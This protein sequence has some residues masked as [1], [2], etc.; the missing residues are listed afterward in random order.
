MYKDIDIPIRTKAGLRIE[1]VGE[2]RALEHDDVD[3]PFVQRGQEPRQFAEQPQR[4]GCLRGRRTAK[5][6]EAGVVTQ[7]QIAAEHRRDPR[8]DTMLRRQF[9]E[10]VNLARLSSG[11]QCALRRRG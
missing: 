10:A 5:V 6:F 4:A 9:R 7:R 3:V 1:L 2:S 11:K 8:R